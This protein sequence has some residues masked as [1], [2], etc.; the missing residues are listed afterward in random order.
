M[1]NNNGDEYVSFPDTTSSEQQQQIVDN[2]DK[3]TGFFAQFALLLASLPHNY[4]DLLKVLSDGI[5]D[6]LFNGSN[7][8]EAQTE[9]ISRSIVCRNR[10]CSTV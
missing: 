1:D 10:T 8:F 4:I 3:K 9:V 5:A 6:L 7:R 2:V